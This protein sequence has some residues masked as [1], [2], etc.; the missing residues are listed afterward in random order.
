MDD[1]EET[2]R[3]WKIRKTIM[4]VRSGESARARRGGGGAFCAAGLSP[5]ELTATSTWVR[6]R[7][8]LEQQNT[9]GVQGILKTKFHP[10]DK[11]SCACLKKCARTGNPLHSINIAG[12]HGA[13]GLQLCSKES[14][15]QIPGEGLIIVI[16]VELS[17]SEAVCFYARWLAWLYSIIT[18]GLTACCRE[19]RYVCL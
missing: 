13:P 12:L 1:E 3:L 17:C 6:R 4:Q 10:R 5:V 9:G 8:D 18:K 16:T 15:N 2:Y 11:P 7:V 14:L 19:C